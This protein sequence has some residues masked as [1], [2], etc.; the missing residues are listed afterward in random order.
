MGQPARGVEI[1]EGAGTTFARGASLAGARPRSRWA[2]PLLAWAMALAVGACG[3]E[4]GGKTHGD[5]DPAHRTSDAGDARNPDDGDSSEDGGMPG[6]GNNTGDDSGARTQCDCAH[7]TC[8]RVADPETGDEMQ[9]C[10]CDRGWTGAGCDACATG[11]DGED[12]ASC[13][14]GFFGSLSDPNLCNPDPCV[15]DPCNGNG[16]CSLTSDPTGID[17]ATC[18]C[19]EGRSGDHCEL[20]AAG[21][22]GESCEQCALGY[23]RDAAGA[24]VVSACASVSCGAHGTCTDQA[25]QGVCSCDA[26]WKGAACDACAEGFLPEQ[27][28]CVPGPCLG[29]DCGDGTCFD[30]TGVA[31]CLCPR[32]YTGDG[33]DSCASGF[34]EVASGDATVCANVLPVTDLRLVAQYDAAAPGTFDLTGDRIDGWNISRG[35][36]VL[37]PESKG[38]RPR[39]TLLPPAVQFSGQEWMSSPS[40]VIRT[41]SNYTVFLVATWK[42]DAGRQTLI[43]TVYVADSPDYREAYSLDALDVNTVRFRHRGP[44]DAQS[45]VVTSTSFNANSGRQLII[46]RRGLLGNSHVITLSNGTTTA[47]AP[48][49]GGTFQGDVMHYVGRCHGEGNQT[50]ALQGNIHELIFYEGAM[51]T[52]QLDSIEAYLREKW[53]L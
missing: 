34:I 4:G 16:S 24:C 33:C 28:H 9:R 53:S 42:P 3:S 13:A 5:D 36:G 14:E 37:W 20:C 27:G 31:A 40:K 15:G 47:A 30:A 38:T 1:R 8:E 25:G 52:E 18:A 7:G 32:G 29:V 41:G 19:S 23:S 11:Y 2:P 12:C 46:L 17:V 10:V 21:Y 43:D 22:E 49:P 45:D 35:Y 44:H 51:T 26:G 48:S 39:Y 6:G 50:C